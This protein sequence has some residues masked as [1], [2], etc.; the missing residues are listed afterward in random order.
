MVI[1]SECVGQLRRAHVAEGSELGGAEALK[2]SGRSGDRS[3]DLWSG[4]ASNGQEPGLYFH[5]EEL[6]FI[7]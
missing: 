5:A 2:Q 3:I 4:V 1:D 6:C 7:L